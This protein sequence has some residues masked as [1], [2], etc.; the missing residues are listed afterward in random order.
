MNAEYVLAINMNHDIECKKK[1]IN[2]VQLI[3]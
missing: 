3:M 2:Y 1:F